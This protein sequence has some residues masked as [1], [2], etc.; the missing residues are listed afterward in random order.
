MEKTEDGG[1]TIDRT[2]IEVAKELLASVGLFFVV[3]R[4]IHY[5]LTPGC[6]DNG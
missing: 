6:K 1:L 3:T 5:L 2:T 4:V